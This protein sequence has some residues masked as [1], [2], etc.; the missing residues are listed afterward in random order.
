[1]GYRERKRKFCWLC[2]EYTQEANNIMY[3]DTKRSSL[4]HTLTQAV[5]VGNNDP[6]Y[7][8]T[9]KEGIVK[10]YSLFFRRNFLHSTY[11]KQLKSFFTVGL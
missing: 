5:S 11:D 6:T 2:K 1:M 8:I 3:V 7:S 10:Y 4:P 9:T